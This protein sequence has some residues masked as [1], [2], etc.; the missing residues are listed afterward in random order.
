MPHQRASDK[1]PH[2]GASPRRLGRPAGAEA[3]Q[4]AVARPGPLTARD[5]QA[6]Q[7]SHGNRVVSRLVEGAQRAPAIQRKGGL[8]KF[9]GGQWEG[10]KQDM[11]GYGDMLRQG[12][13]DNP[14]SAYE[15]F[16][17]TEEDKQ[18]KGF[19]QSLK[20]G[21]QYAMGGLAAGLTGLFSGTLALGLG[22]AGAAVS[23]VGRG[24]VTGLRGAWSGLKG[25]VKGA[26]RGLKGRYELM[27]GKKGPG[28]DPQASNAR[29][30]TSQTAATVLNFVTNQSVQLAVQT[31]STA[32]TVT[33]A[34]TG[35][36]G[37]LLGAIKG[38]VSAFRAHRARKRQQQAESTAEELQRAG[39]VERQLEEWKSKHEGASETDIQTARSEIEADRDTF[40]KAV[41]YL[42]GKNKA[43]KWR[44]IMESTG[45]FVGTAGSTALTAGMIAGAVGLTALLA[46]NPVGWGIALALVGASLLGTIGYVL[47]K[48]I[49][50]AVL[51]SQ[52][53]AAREKYARDFLMLVKKGFQPA[54]QF[55][56]E[57]GVLKAREED[58]KG[59]FTL[60]QF[61]DQSNETQSVAY[62][63]SKMRST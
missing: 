47:Y 30:D 59:K 61:T 13:V 21:A 8:S 46:S 63:K 45:A 3:I 19:G 54:I 16:A 28:F 14:M 53:G 38:A 48:M 18:K 60:A 12:F 55:L 15:Y 22:A 44:M 40:L 42:G 11:S 20:R 43:K 10:Y 4:R 27:S 17:P 35:P 25:M 31:G 7:R 9:A 2:P 24:L 37:A 36:F 23:T 49:N 6:L 34:V 56:Q 33:T 57:I 39:F 58:K 32:A 50:S 26:G 41:L 51:G 52:K 62:L 5:V 29:N 1:K